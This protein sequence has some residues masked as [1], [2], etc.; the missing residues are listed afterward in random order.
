[1]ARE[2]AQSPKRRVRPIVVVLAVALAALLA[3]STSDVAVSGRAETRIVPPINRMMYRPDDRDR[4]IADA[5]DV[6]VA[7]CMAGQGLDYTPQVEHVTGDEALA[8]LRPFGLESLENIGAEPL[9]PEPVRDE[10]YARALFGDPDRRMV[11]HGERLEISWP[12]TGCQ[13]DAEHRLLGDQRQRASELRLRLYDG[14]RDAKEQL[15]R[16]RDFVAINVSWRKCM[17]RRG[18]DAP[19]PADLLSALPA[20][21]NLA[22]D[23]AARADLQCKQ[24]T[25][26]LHTAY[27]RLAFLQQQWLDAHGELIGE[28][29]ALRQRQDTVARQVLGSS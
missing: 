12:A 4:R 1:R 15:D 28:W 21:T 16:D 14:E 27:A 20:D 7:G 19:D 3:G 8:A 23:P 10:R 26:Y 22:T 9:P 17:N 29:L 6:L 18:I 13:A 5:K 25:G 2:R 24:E 11:A